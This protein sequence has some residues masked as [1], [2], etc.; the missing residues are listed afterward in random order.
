MP[1]TATLGRTNEIFMD[2]FDNMM[3]LLRYLYMDP[4][5]QIKLQD[6]FGHSV[7][8]TMYDDG[9]IKAH[10]EAFDIT[11]DYTG[12][13]T[14]ETCPDIRDQLLEQPP[15]TKHTAFKNRYDEIRFDVGTAVALNK[16]NIRKR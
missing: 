15:V 5:N 6:E 12:N 3:L 13:I 11:T 16:Q 4:S 14:V 10:N 7:I 1:D 2:G 8:L 9:T